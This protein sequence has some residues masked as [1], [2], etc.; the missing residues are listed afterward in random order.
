MTGVHTDTVDVEFSF[1]E[2]VTFADVLNVTAGADIPEVF[3]LKFL[4]V[5]SGRW[6][7]WKSLVTARGA[8][9]QDVFVNTTSKK[10]TVRLT[11]SKHELAADVQYC[12]GAFQSGVITDYRSE[13][14]QA[15]DA[16]NVWNKLRTSFSAYSFTTVGTATDTTAPAVAAYAVSPLHDGKIILDDGADT[17]VHAVFNKPLAGVAVESGTV[18]HTY[19]DGLAD[20]DKTTGEMDRSAEVLTVTIADFASS[21]TSWNLYLPNAE[22]GKNFVNMT[23]LLPS[24]ATLESS[25]PS[26]TDYD[27]F[28]SV[29]TVVLKFSEVVQAGEG[30]V[31]LSAVGDASDDSNTLTF[32]VSSNSTAPIYFTGVYMILEPAEMMPG[33][34]YEVSMTNNTI[35]GVTGR[36]GIAESTYTP[37]TYRFATVPQIRFDASAKSIASQGAGVTFGPDNA[38]LVIGGETDISGTDTNKTRASTTYRDTDA[39]AGDGKRSVCTRPCDDDAT[40]TVERKIYKAPS[41]GGFRKMDVGSV[42]VSTTPE[43]A[44]ALYPLADPVACVCPTCMFAPPKLGESSPRTSGPP[45]DSIPMHGH[46]ATLGAYTYDTQIAASSQVVPLVCNVGPSTEDTSLKPT[47]G[48][49][50]AEHFSCTI[51]SMG[52]GDPYA[53]TAEYFGVWSIDEAACAPKPCLTYPESLGPIGGLPTGYSSTN[54]H[55]MVDELGNFSLPS[56]MNC[57]VECSAGYMPTGGAGDAG[58]LFECD[59]GIYGF[60]V[61][62]EKRAC[63][64]NANGVGVA[65]DFA[66]TTV[67][68]GDTL[69]VVCAPGYKALIAS[70]VCTEDSSEPES[71][72]KLVP[73]GDTLSCEPRDAVDPLACGPVTIAD[74]TNTCETAKFGESCEVTCAT[75]M[76]PSTGTGTIT[77]DGAT[78]AWTEM[79]CIPVTCETAATPSTVTNSAGTAGT[80]TGTLALGETCSVPCAEGYAGNFDGTS[81]LVKCNAVTNGGSADA[82]DGTCA[83]VT[84]SA[85]QVSATAAPYTYAC[86]AGS[87]VAGTTSATT[88][89]VC[90]WSGNF[91]IELETGGFEDVV[92]VASGSSATKVEKTVV[93]TAFEVTAAAKDAMCADITPSGNM[94]SLATSMQKT[95]CPDGTNCPK[96]TATPTT[97]GDCDTRR[98]RLLS[99]ADTVTFSVD[100]AVETT[101]MSATDAADL[102]STLTGADFAAELEAAIVAEIPAVGDGIKGMVVSAPKTV[103]EYTV[104]EDPKD[105]GESD[106]GMSP[107][108]IIVALLLLVGLGFG[109]FKM[110]QGSS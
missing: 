61:T 97:E 30:T 107:V 45:D 84:C 19:G 78:P 62:C 86:A 52:E 24:R 91:K 110:K 93:S 59:R 51:A 69:E 104:K 44:K 60:E 76:M 79:T 50:P 63:T 16:T 40:S 41:K 88:P 70:A 28:S 34:I 37:S 83:A 56:G 82:G 18:L 13:S 67:L 80:C 7:M 9:G 49:E 31:S 14:S 39:L 48:Y 57:T 42:Y 92:C 58:R 87:V 101:S 100:F 105:G 23:A 99:D 29:S 74:S 35:R 8:E 6:D 12:V 2:A 68:F 32:E 5:T 65:T 33:E 43:G 72:V 66:G 20:T 3:E 17:V 55:T 106:E 53:A 73:D 46:F 22:T 15:A 90:H 71:P 103:V 38:L 1:S 75:G 21:T 25:S 95:I 109:A 108:V 96:V 85:S 81:V 94:P 77:C 54:C 102:T 47:Q 10:I 27:K 89:V 36:N 98:A 4:N 26:G 11:A 64:S